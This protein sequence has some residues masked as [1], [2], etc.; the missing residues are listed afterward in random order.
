MPIKQTWVKTICWLGTS[1]TM[2]LLALPDELLLRVLCLV[3]ISS[4]S[5]A[6]AA[7]R[8]LH[9]LC[10]DRSVWR[11]ATLRVRERLLG[12]LP[13]E[14]PTL[15]FAPVLR[16]VSLPRSTTDAAAAFLSACP[17][18]TT[19]NL[20]WCRQ[21]TDAAAASLS[22]CPALTSLD[23][24]WCRQL[25]DAT[26]ASLSA[27]P[28]LT[29]FDL[30]GCRR[31]TD[32]AAA[33]LSACPALTTLNLSGCLLLTDVAVASFSACPALTTLNLSYCHLLTDAAIV[34]LRAQ[35]VT[36]HH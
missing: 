3:P 10:A 19:I 12:R 25:T 11:D 8:R 15:P 34:S 27:C 20:S 1:V 31:L 30:V 23:L 22:A 2:D 17:A 4:L 28:T 33:S 16:A 6:R 14:L 29:T 24:S 9:A 32:A 35:G 18:L 36:V 13:A 5:G 26:A 7:C 21:L